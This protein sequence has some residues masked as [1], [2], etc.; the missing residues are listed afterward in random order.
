LTPQYVGLP[1]PL[2]ARRAKSE[3][4]VDTQFAI[5]PCYA[6]KKQ[7]PIFDW[8]YDDHNCPDYPTKCDEW[9]DEENECGCGED[10]VD[11][12]GDPGV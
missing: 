10:G 2:V 9:D 7:C 1:C 4:E 12:P 6:P 5:S 11:A 3:A 8:N